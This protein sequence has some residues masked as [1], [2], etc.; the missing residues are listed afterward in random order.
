M[1]P[2]NTTK[3]TVEERGSL[4]TN[5]ANT[6]NFKPSKL[7]RM[8][9]WIILSK[10]FY[11]INL[12]FYYKSKKS[13][14]I[15]YSII[16]CYI[17]SAKSWSII[18]ISM[19]YIHLLFG[20]PRGLWSCTL[21]DIG[22]DK[23][24]VYLYITTYKWCQSSRKYARNE[25]AEKVRK[26]HK[27]NLWLV[28]FKSPAVHFVLGI[29]HETEA[30]HHHMLAAMKEGT[31]RRKIIFCWCKLDSFVPASWNK[32]FA[33]L[34]QT[35]FIASIPR[36]TKISNNLHKKINIRQDAIRYPQVLDYCIVRDWSE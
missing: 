18:F 15:H 25:D 22:L 11:L 2:G 17:S 9:P 30:L 5:Q 35:R 7:R 24:E 26:L 16:D 31:A 19:V 8:K 1:K 12:R 3:R 27:C 34:S 32:A 14:N 36:N 21:F 23:R 29:Q 28:G 10:I 33:K 13:V 4:K 6:K 20:Q